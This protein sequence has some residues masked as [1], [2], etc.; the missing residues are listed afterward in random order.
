MCVF[1]SAILDIPVY[2][3]HIQSLHTLFSLYSEFKNSQ[4][5]T[6]DA[7]EQ[8]LLLLL[9]CCQAVAEGYGGKGDPW[10]GALSLGWHSL[11]GTPLQPS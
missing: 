2:K 11:G 8:R 1:S 9:V 4:V 6:S 5:C 7:P 3:D 10:P